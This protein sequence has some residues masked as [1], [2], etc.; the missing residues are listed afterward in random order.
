MNTPTTVQA[1]PPVPAASRSWTRHLVT[2]VR[3]LLGLAFVVFGANGFL[4]FIPPPPTPLPEGAAAFAGALFKT[5]YMLPLIGATQL[6]AGALLLA[7]RFVPLALVFL[8][9][10]LVNAAVF[11]LVLEPSGLGMTGVFVALELFLVWSYRTAY[12]PLLTPRWP[13]D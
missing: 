3:I 11:H 5:G 2:A 7:N 8:A 10:F 12:R 13:R 9:P 1:R 4:N 6:I